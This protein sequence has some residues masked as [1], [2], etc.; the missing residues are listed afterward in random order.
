MSEQKGNKTEVAFSVDA[1]IINRLGKELVGRAETAVSELIKNAY[2]ADARQ[3]TLNFIDTDNKGGQL[4][5]EDDG[6][7]M[8]FDQMVNGFMRI[9]SAEKIKSP[10]S[11]KYKRQRAGS[12]GIG[13]FATQR[14]G[15]KLTILSQVEGAENSLKLEINWEKFKPDKDLELIK[16]FIQEVDGFRDRK[17]GT[18]LI[19]DELRE[20]WTEAQIRRVFRYISALL[21]PNYLSDSSRKH[22]LANKEKS[23][24]QNYFNV[25]C[26]K[27]V[28]GTI[29][30][31]AD[32]DKMIFNSAIAEINGYVING[33]GICEVKS[34]VFGLNDTL[35][36]EGDYQFIE[37]THFRAYYYIF[38]FESFNKYY[39]G[40]ITKPEY[41][42][43]L[44]YATDN[45]GIKLYRNGFRVAPYGEIGNDWLKIDKSTVRAD[46]NAHV[47]FNNRSFFGYVEVTDPNGERFE[48]T[49]SREGLLENAA[50]KQLANFVHV[51]LLAATRR[52]NSARSAKKKR[53]EEEKYI[54]EL[55]NSPDKITPLTNQIEDLIESKATELREKRKE[56]DNDDAF[57]EYKEK[58][59]REIQLLQRAR[60][61]LREA[62]MM[63]VLAGVGL[64][65]AEFTHEVRQFIPVFKSGIA[66]LL[67]KEKDQDSL[68]ALEDLKSS[69][70]RF[71]SYVAYIDET[72][73]NNTSREKIPIKLNKVVNDFI[74]VINSDATQNN[75]KVERNMYDHEIYTIPMHPSEWNSLLYNLYTNAKKAIHKAG[76]KE[77]RI[78][79]IG[80]IEDD[81][82][83]LE[84]MDNGTGIDDS[85]KPR[86]FDPFFTTS[87]PSYTAFKKKAVIGTGLGLKIVKDIVE[88]YKGKIILTSPEEGFSTCF[89]I[90]LP[91]L[92]KD[93]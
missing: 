37:D 51:A 92:K 73:I 83:Y 84:F 80:G 34:S 17:S 36:I 25:D 69:F 65:I 40:R 67:R 42:K 31:I 1:G 13:R 68:N 88:A 57:Q 2:D 26:Y 54:N 78:E 87:T 29:I 12:K 43:L 75:I 35:D 14:L 4:T 79:L 52:V 24:K 53:E 64:T 3:V 85:I 60:S 20:S 86:I 23:K 63:R 77:G 91:K 16:N 8:N 38:G 27:S 32:I 76:V 55:E 44:E 7:G 56:S 61:E 82:I 70:K 48:E 11:P 10:V 33:R 9:A 30:T 6:H 66:L 71:E 41:N 39:R 19:I 28:D 22:N 49:A 59:N 18:T 72:I 15:K 50:F 58:T 90:E 89:R 74:K 5:I 93:E 81:I 46:D 45:S 62:E 47:P 21:Q